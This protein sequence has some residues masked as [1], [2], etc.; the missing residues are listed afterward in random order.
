MLSPVPVKL[1]P[2]QPRPL[3]LIQQPG[4]GERRRLVLQVV[5]IGHPQVNPIRAHAA[6]DFLSSLPHLSASQLLQKV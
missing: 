6:I 5:G 1:E 4:A 3:V 2:L